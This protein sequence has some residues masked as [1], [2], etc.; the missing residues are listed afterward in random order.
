MIN[1]VIMA[2]GSGKRFWPKSRKNLPKQ[3]L[4]IA[5]KEPMIKE[6]VERLKPIAQK[7]DIYI[8]TG[9]HLEKHIKNIL[10]DVNYIIEPM[11]KNTAACIGLAAIYLDK[12]DIMLIE[13]SDHVYKDVNAYLKHL[14]AGIETAKKN[15]IVLV[16][17]TPDFPHTGYGYIHQ[18]EL[19]RKKDSIEIYEVA[20]FNE[21]PDPETAEIFFKSGVFLWNSG[22]F[23]SNVKTM[24]DAIKKHMPELYSALMKIKNSNFDKNIMS[25]EF[26]KLENTSIDYGVIEKAKNLAVVRGDF[27]WDDVGDWKSMERIYPKDKNNNVVLADYNGNAKNCIIIGDKKPIQAE[28]IEDLIIIDTVDCLLVCSKNRSQDVKKIVQMLEKDSELK[29]YTTEIQSRPEFHKVSL[30]CKNIEVK[31][32]CL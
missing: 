21:K 11:P 26:E 28:N 6:T 23:I 7:K 18:G 14:K 25:K 22:I 8:A 3:C 32:S 19:I 2:G 31:S 24:L 20:E 10:S 27:H 5:S 17:I 13:T 30:D 12:E 9:K 4:P 15:K 16:G 1:I 29:K